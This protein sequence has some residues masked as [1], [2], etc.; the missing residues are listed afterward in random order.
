MSR[1]S[2]QRNAEGCDTVGIGMD[3][4][5]TGVAH[6]FILE[7]VLSTAAALILLLLS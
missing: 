7:V 6:A 5:S 2:D 1:A 4:D 3:D